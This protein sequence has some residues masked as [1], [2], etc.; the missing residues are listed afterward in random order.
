MPVYVFASVVFFAS[1]MT[2][3]E[4]PAVIVI[5]V[6]MVIGSMLLAPALVFKYVREGG[7]PGRPRRLMVSAVRLP[8]PER[9]QQL[10]GSRRR[11]VGAPG[12]LR[13]HGPR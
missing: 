6:T 5:I 9:R 3:F 12:A 8:A 13:G 4:Q 1:F 7:R 2:G 11:M 10:L